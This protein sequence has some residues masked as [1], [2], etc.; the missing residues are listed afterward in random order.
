VS[1][2]IRILGEGVANMIA[3]GEVVEAPFSVVKELVENALDAG[4]TEIAIDIK[5]GGSDLVR[6]A[7]NGHG[8]TRDDALTAFNRFAT[9]KLTTAEDLLAI[10]TL[11]FRGEALPSI[12]S[13][14]RVRLVT[15][16]EGAHEG[17]EVNLVGGE[18]RDVRPAGR[19]PGT[20][21]EVSSLF[22]N[23]PARRKFLR[24]D[25]VELHRIMD[26][27]T[28]Y[29]V[30]YPSVRLDVAVDGK[31]ALG[32]AVAES[33]AERVAGVLGASVSKEMLP[34][35]YAEDGGTVTG[36]VGR[37]TIA[38][39]RGAQ[40]VVA[41]NGR[42]VRS[43]L[44]SAAI[45]SGY[46]ELLPQNRHPV[47]FLMLTLEPG[48]VDVNV[49]PTKREVRFGDTRRIFGLVENAV[50]KG[51]MSHDTAPTLATY[52]ARGAAGQT[53]AHGGRTPPSWL[54][55]AGVPDGTS[56]ARER[57]PAPAGTTATE[58]ELAFPSAV[59]EARGEGA[60]DELRAGTG[61]DDQYAKFWQLHQS[62]IFVQ[63][64]EGVLVV[65]QH[66]A[67][68]RV[69]Y[70]KARVALSGAAESG[71]SQQLLF[72]VAVELSPGEWGSFDEARHL[73][74][75]LGFSIREMS[76]RTVLMEAVPGA[77]PRWPH[78]RILHDILDDL[79]SGSRDVRGLVETIAKTVACKA[80]IKAGD[81]LTQDEMRSLI[82]QLFATELPYSCPHG[83]PTFMRMTSEEL[84]K[85]FGRT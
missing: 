57:S 19:A 47:V 51:L 7:D 16:E 48:L 44:I 25:S 27:L 69:L 15:C 76:G 34:V 67:H 85:R 29:A 74:A 3:A 55:G 40:Q 18:V 23:T 12:A 9:S 45:R 65:D 56:A 6:V 78:D 42:P 39:P 75:R 83:R 38:R 64:R 63:T 26:L 53:A 35:S 46:G 8:M 31:L 82:D 68:E 77:F 24:S 20:T 43:R 28:E 36:L 11:G 84:D 52:E 21:V 49:H 62:Y 2:R 72:P 80:A 37:P 32:L 13:V 17:T 81:R 22:F 59:R 61:A 66:A 1:S 10:A 73:L 58:Q 71:P 79:P 5:G 33:A 41:V 60:P 54:A 4:A 30:L 70:E 50:R 14:S